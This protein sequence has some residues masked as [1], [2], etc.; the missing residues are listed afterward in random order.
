MSSRQLRRAIREWVARDDLVVDGDQPPL[1]ETLENRRREFQLRREVVD[2]GPAAERLDQLEQGALLRRSLEDVVSMD[3]RRK[4][5]SHFRDAT[6]ALR[7]RRSIVRRQRRRQRA[8][9]DDAERNHVVLGDPFAEREHS[10]AEHGR[11]VGQTCDALRRDAVRRLGRHQRRRRSR[12]GRETERQRACQAARVQ[13]PR[14]RPR[15]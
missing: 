8:A 11:R 6:R 3:E 2:R 12:A 10:V 14:R 4:I 9:N 5:A 7:R 1:D 13:R 15:T